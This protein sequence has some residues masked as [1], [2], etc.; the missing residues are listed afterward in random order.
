[1]KFVGWFMPKSILKNSRPTGT[2]TK[3]NLTSKFNTDPLTFTDG[4][5]PGTVR[6]VMK[7]VEEIEGVY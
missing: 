2:G 7:F 3:Y 6:T 5:V 1:M 4:L